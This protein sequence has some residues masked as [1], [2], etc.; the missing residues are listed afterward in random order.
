MQVVYF[1]DEKLGNVEWEL[2][3]DL[4]NHI[5]DLPKEEQDI[6]RKEFEFHVRGYLKLLVDVVHMGPRVHKA[7][8][9]LDEGRKMTVLNLAKLR[10]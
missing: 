2:P 8:D 10:Q 1:T 9:T 7:L 6:V 5:S 3:I 4:A